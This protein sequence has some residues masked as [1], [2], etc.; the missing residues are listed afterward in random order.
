MTRLMAGIL[1]LDLVVVIGVVAGWMVAGLVVLV[2]ESL[3][4]AAYHVALRGTEQELAH[5]KRV[6][7]TVRPDEV[8]AARQRLA[9]QAEIRQRVALI[10]REGVDMSADGGAGGRW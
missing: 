10:E 3:L 7:A 9:S 6:I 4:L 2:V 8:E 5:C 1:M